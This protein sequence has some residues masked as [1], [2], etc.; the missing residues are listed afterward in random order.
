MKKVLGTLIIFTLLTFGLT[1]VL[2]AQST[3]RNGFSISPPSFDINANPGDKLTNTIKVENISDQALVI[4]A[5]AQNFAA[6]GQEGQI[7]IIEEDSEYSITSWISF[8]NPEFVVAPGETALFNFDI[9]IPQQSDP[10]SHY[11]AIVFSTNSV[12]T[13]PNTPN[14]VQ[15]I[16]SIILL[17][18]PGEVNEN[19]QLV[20]FDSDKDSYTEPK[21]K[22]NTLV[23]NTGSVIVKPAG[24]ITIKDLLGNTV[25]VVEVSG[26]NIL[27]GSERLFDQ[28]FDFDKIGYFK[29][30]LEL[31]YGEEG[32]LLT[33][34]TSFTTLYTQRLV[35]AII[36]IIV[37]IG[38]YIL[39]RKR[40]NKAISVIV[41]G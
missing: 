21:V 10:G 3:A 29:A 17:R 37:L 18:L 32:H 40:I 41:K 33:A 30:V 22:L 25:Q 26:K 34:E 11:G 15:E 38:L 31:K 28:E 7:N 23:K 16:A 27:P 6:Y 35:P 24:T 2:K 19:A 1:G 12:S 13:T 20:N 8:V 9:N 14:I 39:L 5:E 36:G 4:K